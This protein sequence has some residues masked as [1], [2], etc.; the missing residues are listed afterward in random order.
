MVELIPIEKNIDISNVTEES[1]K[2]NVELTIDYYEK[3][4]FIIAVSSHVYA[5]RYSV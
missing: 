3:I 4:G 2:S 1:A 5:C